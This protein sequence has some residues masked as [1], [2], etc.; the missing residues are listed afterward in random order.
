MYADRVQLLK[1]MEERRKSRAILYVTGDRPGL[2]TQIHQEVYDYFVNLLDD[3]GIIDRIS[4][5]LYTRGG[6]TLA[7]WSIANLIQQF[8]KT[9][10]VIVP[11]KAHSAG[12]LM[13]LGAKH[14]V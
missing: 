5:I 11:S 9:F 8:C 7:G 3:I 6:S 4:L 13:S 12:T 1:V 10:E 14:I 2:E